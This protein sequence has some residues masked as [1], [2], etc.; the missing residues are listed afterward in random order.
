MS[1]TGVTVKPI[2]E[3]RIVNAVVHTDR[4]LGGSAEVKAEFLAWSRGGRKDCLC[5]QRTKT[6]TA[7]LLG[8][9]PSIQTESTEACNKS[10]VTV[11]PVAHKNGRIKIVGGRSKDRPGAPCL[12]KVLQMLG[13]FTDQAVCLNIRHCPA[14]SRIETCLCRFLSAVRFQRE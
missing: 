9:Q 12:Q 11:G 2:D 8:D 4:T 3:E 13:Q 7:A 6:T 5:D 10:N 1:V 14:A